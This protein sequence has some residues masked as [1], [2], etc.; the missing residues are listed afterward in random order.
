MTL[1]DVAWGYIID[2]LKMQFVVDPLYS[3]SSILQVKNGPARGEG[4]HFLFSEH[5][6]SKQKP[7]TEVF[8]FLFLSLDIYDTAGSPFKRPL[9]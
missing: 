2:T 7:H 5:F 4:R 3:N 1:C 8:I 9:Q 6:S